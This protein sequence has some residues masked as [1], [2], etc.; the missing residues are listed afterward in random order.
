MS[1]WD[2]LGG[3]SAASWGGT[4][5]LHAWIALARGDTFR[6]GPHPHA[7]FDAGNVFAGLPDDYPPP[8]TEVTGKPFTFGPHPNAK[9]DDDNFFSWKA[10][11][12]V[13]R[14]PVEKMWVDVSCDVIDV[15]IHAG[16][17]KADG[18]MGRAEAGT[19]TIVLADPN[20][21]F[22]PI[23][24]ASK[25]MYQ[26]RTRLTPGVPVIVWAEVLQDDV[27]ILRRT[28]FV[29]KA[30]SF[31]EPWVRDPAARRCTIQAADVIAELANRK[32]PALDSPVGAGEFVHERLQRIIDAFGGPPLQLADDSLVPLQASTLEG[33]AW[34][35]INKAVDDEIGYVAPVPYAQDP[36]YYLFRTE[37][38]ALRFLPRS[39][40]FDASTPV[41]TVPC[42][43]ITAAT[44]SALDLSLRNVVTAGRTGGPPVTV[45][46]DRSVAL[47][48]EH[49]F[50]RTDLGVEGDDDAAQWANVVLG[51]DAFPDVRLQDITLVPAAAPQLWWQILSV[52]LAVD[53]VVVQ[54][55]P[56]GASTPYVVTARVI[57]VEHAINFDRWTVKWVLGAT[58]T[59]GRFFTFG[60]H[61]NAQ[62]DNGN[63]FAAF[64]HEGPISAF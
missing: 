63:V 61:D 50:S 30:T 2:A 51:L 34:E 58:E 10:E 5:R 40:W 4:V 14:E 36:L 7:R 59:A 49:P 60:P 44:V 24:G 22:D 38:Q 20:Q 23:N 43:I 29:G 32:R 8:D 27:F 6:Y 9:F 1:V 28:L 48:G 39:T 57:G 41:M 19:A 55:M 13:I 11:P 17:T 46:N 25:W 21:D 54:W 45:R 15:T 53:R 16:A 33:S 37:R 3:A 64:A 26:G 56:E 31:T 42:S 18:V 52:D 12:G 35:L 62:F 47:Y